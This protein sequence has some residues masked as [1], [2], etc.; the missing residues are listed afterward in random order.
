MTT[1]ELKWKYSYQLAALRTKF[2]DI[3]EKN[4]RQRSW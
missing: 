2:R 4:A 1:N 3:F